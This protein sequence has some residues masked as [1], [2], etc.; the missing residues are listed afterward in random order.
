MTWGWVQGVMYTHPRDRPKYNNDWPCAVGDCVHVC[1]ICNCM[2]I[3]RRR[4]FATLPFISAYFVMQVCTVFERN[5]MR[6]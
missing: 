5:F 1:Y 2:Y 4:A 3:C 6:A